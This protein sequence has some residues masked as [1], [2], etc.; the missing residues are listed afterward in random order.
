[1]NT[2]P[3]SSLSPVQ[4]KVLTLLAAGVPLSHA[5]EQ[6]GISRQ[7]IY[8]WQN[9]TPAFA[10]SLEDAQSEYTDTLKDKLQQLS[11][12]ALD[13]LNQIFDDPKA[14]SGVRL[15]AAL[16]VLKRPASPYA[17]GWNLPVSLNP[18]AQLLQDEIDYLQASEKHYRLTKLDTNSRPPANP[19]PPPPPSAPSAQTPRSAPCPCGS[20]E[21]FKRCCG[22]D[23]PPV[24]HHNA[25]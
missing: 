25:A 18:N 23:A 17:R 20:G 5:A 8:N 2:A 1:M 6:A 16:A 13:A 21:K 3:A 19:A 24:L 4:Q 14:P 9:S 10:Q 22:K 7:T 12:K 11:A 15:R